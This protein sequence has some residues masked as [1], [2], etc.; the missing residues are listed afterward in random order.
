MTPLDFGLAPAFR[1]R[2]SGATLAA[3][4][5]GSITQI[6]ITSAPQSL[7]Q[8]S[9]TVLNAYPAMRWTHSSDAALFDVGAS[10][11]V[12]M[13]YADR[14]QRLF[15]GEIT[16]VAPEFPESGAPTLSLTAHNRM[17]WLTLGQHTRTFQ[18]VT[19]GDIVARIASEANLG[20]R[21]DRTDERYPHVPQY[22]RTDLDFLLERAS[23]TNYELL[24][25]GRTLV[26]RRPPQEDRAAISLEWGRTLKSFRPALEPSRQ[27]TGVTVRGYDPATKEAIVGEAGPSTQGSGNGASKSGAEVLSED[28][29]RQAVA[30]EVFPP[31]ATQQ[32]ADARAAARFADHARDTVLGEGSCVGTPELR[33]GGVVDLT[34]LGPRFSGTYYIAEATHSLGRGGYETRF[35]VSRSVVG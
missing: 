7:D 18:D 1:V 5:A 34:G 24:V 13:G 31:P 20:S 17:H 26:F 28:L 32:E 16:R 35:S 30:V 14:L 4:V 12:E 25:E 3:E 29:G 19:D 9:F 21:V 6:T 2:V 33:A 15:D 8:C 10:V 27:V 23:R 22:N 11:E